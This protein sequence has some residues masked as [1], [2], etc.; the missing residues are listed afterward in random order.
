MSTMQS[1]TKNMDEK[2]ATI[3]F[4]QFGD[5]LSLRGLVDD[6]IDQT[7]LH[8]RIQ[9]VAVLSEKSAAYAQLLQSGGRYQLETTGVGKHRKGESNRSIN[10]LQN[11]ISTAQWADVLHYATLSSLTC[12]FTDA[13][14]LPAQPS[15]DDKY[16]N[17]RSLPGWIAAFMHARFL[18]GKRGLAIISLEPIMHNGLLLKGA[19]EGLCKKWGLD[20]VFLHWLREENQF[21]CS[22]AERQA[23]RMLPENNGSTNQ[24]IDDYILAEG[25]GAWWMDCSTVPAAI[26]KLM[27]AGANIIYGRNA[28]DTFWQKQVIWQ[29]AALGITLLRTSL[30]YSNPKQVLAEDGLRR[31]VANMLLTEALPNLPLPYEEGLSFVAEAFERLENQF[32]SLVEAIPIGDFILILRRDIVPLIVSRFQKGQ[33][34]KGLVLLSAIVFMHIIAKKPVEYKELHALSC[35]MEPGM[36]S[37]S[38]LADIPMW[39]EDLRLI[40]G[41]AQALSSAFRDLQLLGIKGA[42]QQNE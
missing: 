32:F 6:W 37:Y 41:F 26:E 9:G 33:Q 24:T 42:I 31:Y 8:E 40:E 13:S 36:L 15:K 30:G 38:L 7:N 1:R 19:V 25:F 16:D 20:D 34:S 21:I 28:L 11:V 22:M 29:T 5:G 27:Q 17:P 2:Q 39:G 14:D 18:A 23:W 35:D 12:V 10:C 4:I 3:S